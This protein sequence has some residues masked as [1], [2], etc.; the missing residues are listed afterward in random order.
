MLPATTLDQNEGF[1][2]PSPV[3][4]LFRRLKQW[5]QYYLDAWTPYPLSRWCVAVGLLVLFVI[6]II[7][8]QSY[9]LGLD[10]TVPFTLY[11]W[12]GVFALNALF[13][14]RIVIGQVSQLPSSLCTSSF[15][16]LNAL[17]LMR[18]VIGQ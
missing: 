13:L 10:R 12:L 1:E 7:V 14:M 2:Q 17:F 8:K 18:I 6:R 16:V 11:R 5:Q 4:K 3:V 9:Q 15:V